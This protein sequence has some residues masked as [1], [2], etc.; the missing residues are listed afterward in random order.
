MNG[1]N[2][3]VG[4][5]AKE[6]G[7]WFSRD[8]LLINAYWGNKASIVNQ[9]GLDEYTGTEYTIDRW[10]LDAKDGASVTVNDGY[11]RLTRTGT[12]NIQA[13][14]Q[15]VNSPSLLSERTVTLSF[16]HRGTGTTHLLFAYITTSFGIIGG[17]EFTN[18]NDWQLDSIT[19]TLPAG[20]SYLSVY[21]YCNTSLQNGYTD[22]LAAKLEE[23]RVQT[24]AHREN[25]VWVLNRTTR[26]EDELSRCLSN[27]LVISKINNWVCVG[28]GLPLSATS[29]NIQVSLPV[30][31]R[32]IPTVRYTGSF[33]LIANG[34]WGNAIDIT[35]MS[36][37]HV[38]SNSLILECTTASDVDVNKTYFL[39][40]KNNS[41]DNKI[42]IDANP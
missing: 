35:S 13:F 15:V 31:L 22:V 32:A 42:I 34:T 25:G 37:V 41:A 11:I 28:I 17:K 3:I 39:A 5:D 36:V 7:R 12:D 2:D 33:G 23:G 27:Q 18:T 26:Y 38:M 30:P 14:T 16:L 24:L 1:L 29:V 6:A 10:G 20:L 8:N 21:I 4:Q 19:V 9:R 40:S